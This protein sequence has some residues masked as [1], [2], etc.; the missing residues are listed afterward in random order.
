[1]G[2]GGG[3]RRKMEL[4]VVTGQW[5]GRED[6]WKKDSWESLPMPID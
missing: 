4:F 6:M 3:E 1:M 5:K 2:G